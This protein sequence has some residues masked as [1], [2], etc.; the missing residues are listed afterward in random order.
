MKINFQKLISILVGLVIIFSTQTKSLAFS[1]ELNKELKGTIILY[2]GE[3]KAYVNGEEK[4]IDKLNTGVYPVI[5]NDKTLVPVRF[6]SES[7]GATVEIKD[8][9]ISI[10][11]NDK[12]VLLEIGS[13][14]IIVN[15][16]ESTMTVESQILNDRTFIPLRSL[17]EALGKKLFWDDRGLIIISNNEKVINQ[18]DDTIIETMVSNF[19]HKGNSYG[20]NVNYGEIAQEGE[21][22]YYSDDKDK[23]YKVKTDGSQKTKISDYS[24]HNINVV[25][26]WI[27][28]SLYNY[29]DKY[30][31]LGLYKIKTDGSEKIKLSDDNINCINIIGDSIYYINQSD[32]YKPYKMGIDGGNRWRLNDF[33]MKCLNVIGSRAYFQ[34][35]MNGKLY[36]MNIDGSDVQKIVDDSSYNLNLNVA[37]GWIFYEAEG[38]LHGLYKI[39]TDGT[40]RQ[41]LDSSQISY[42]NVKDDWIYYGIY[43]GGIYKIK[44]DGT[45]KQK[46][47]DDDQSGIYIIGDLIFYE[48][49]EN[50]TFKSLGIFKMNFDGSN[51][52]KL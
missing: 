24:A 29:D 34:N 12:K 50:N 48:K 38:G 18:E 15:G 52:Q 20:N 9:E 2:V 51:N 14:K 6:I 32:Y 43:K 25:N 21:W 42:I 4:Q 40:G 47:S 7:F 28:C 10:S 17:S 44:I 19:I 31:N 13:T 36:S 37:D 11:L 5:I 22:I 16:N 41:K 26:D 3:S 33:P 46:L 8:N 30:S 49:R 27:Y 1:S 35:D 45:G 23:F 39:K